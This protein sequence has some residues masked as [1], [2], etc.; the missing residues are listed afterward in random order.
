MVQ[1]NL[2]Q[3]SKVL[4]GKYYKDKSDFYLRTYNNW[5]KGIKVY[6]KTFSNHTLPPYPWN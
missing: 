5:E 4:K 1:F 2:P 3:N 6:N